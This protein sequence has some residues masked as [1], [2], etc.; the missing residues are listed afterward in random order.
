[1][2]T[3]ALF[4]L[5]IAVLGLVVASIIQTIIL[6]SVRSETTKIFYN[7]LEVLTLQQRAKQR[8]EKRGKEARRQEAGQ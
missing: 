4:A 1:M 3:V 8:E 5:T 2:S 6:V 7:V